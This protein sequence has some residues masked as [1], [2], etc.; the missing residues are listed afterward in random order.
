MRKI[1]YALSLAVVIAAAAAIVFAQGPPPTSKG[2][3]H[4]PDS[5]IQHLAD[6]GVRAHTNHL[7]F[8]RSQGK[9]TKPIPPTGPTGMFPAPLWEYYTGTDYDQ[10]TGSNVIVIVDAYHYATALNDFNYF[11]QQFGL[12]RESSTNPMASTNTVFQVVYATGKQPRANCGWA[13]EAALDIEWAHAM[14]PKAKIIL[15]EAAS[16][17]FADLFV[18]VDKATTLVPDSGGQ[19]SMSWGGSEFSTEANYDSHFPTNGDVV[20]FASSGDAGGKTIYPSVSPYVVAAGGTS[21]SFTG[22]GDA[23]SITN[24]KGWSGSGGGPSLYEPKPTYQYDVT[25]PDTLG[26]RR[27]VPDVSFDADPYSGVSVYDSTS[28]QGYVGWMVFGG[29]SVSSPA[30]AGLTN[31]AGSFA[32]DSVAELSLIY[33]PASSFRDITTGTAGSYSAGTGWDFVTGIGTPMLHTKM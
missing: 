25:M 20:Y 26:E 17:S 29:T 32:L 14:A 9:P 7:I 11:S 24:E 6:I 19:V 10:A 16:S 4:I 15:V 18:A 8:V 1:L 2:W 23:T 12:P 31:S 21:L 22:S 27:G 3:I 5:T 33:S 13:Q 30:L 28:C